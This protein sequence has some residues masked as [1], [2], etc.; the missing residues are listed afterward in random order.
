MTPELADQLWSEQLWAHHPLLVA[1]PAF[2]PAI[3]LAGVVMYV[4]RKDRREEREENELLRRALGDEE[5][6]EQ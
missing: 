3:A 4:V 5:E 1:I 2:V 6:D